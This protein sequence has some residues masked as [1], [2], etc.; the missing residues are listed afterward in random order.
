MW[1]RLGSGPVPGHASSTKGTS[2]TKVKGHALAWIADLRHAFI[3]AGSSGAAVAAVAAHDGGTV[4]FDVADRR[5]IRRYGDGPVTEEYVR[6]RT[7]FTAFTGAPAFVVGDDGAFLVEELIVGDHLLHVPT[8]ARVTT[9]RRLIEDFARLTAH[10]GADGVGL[11]ERLEPV[12]SSLDGAPAA[13]ARWVSADLRGLGERMTWIP[14]AYEATA[15]NLIVG[16]GDR[17]VPIDLGDLQVQPFF[18]YPIGVLVDAGGAVLD[19]YR[20]GAFDAQLAALWAAA[21]LEWA[22]DAAQR[23]GVLVARAAFAAA[24]DHDAGVTGGFARLFERRLR[25]IER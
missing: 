18:A 22:S 11:T 14:S 8:D 10:A 4:L 13:K 3:V 21:G 12:L 25:A 16:R 15:K 1:R 24:R 17:P 6:L 2:S 19:A 9:I 7:V 5:V 20:A 23:D